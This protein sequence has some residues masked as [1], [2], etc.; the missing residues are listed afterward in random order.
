MEDEFIKA[1]SIHICIVNT[2]KIQKLSHT[3]KIT[4]AHTAVHTRKILQI[5]N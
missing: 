5:Y 2:Y 4:Y 3:R 1:I